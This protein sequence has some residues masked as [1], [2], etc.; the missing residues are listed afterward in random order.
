MPQNVWT[1]K[2]L[3]ILQTIYTQATEIHNIKERSYFTILGFQ[4]ILFP[5]HAVLCSDHYFIWP[6]SFSLSAGLLVVLT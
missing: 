3:G 2:S 5:P 1:I 4:A 6:K